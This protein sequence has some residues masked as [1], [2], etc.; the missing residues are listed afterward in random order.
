[1][2]T[3]HSTANHEMHRIRKSSLSKFFSR[4]QMLK[5]EDEARDFAQLTVDKMLRCAGKEPFDNKSAFNCFTAECHLPVLLRRAH[6]FHRSGGLGPQLCYVGKAFSRYLLFDE[7]QFPGEKT[8]PIFSHAGRLHWATISRPLIDRRVWLSRG[9]STRL[10]PTLK[11]GE[12]F[13]KCPSPSHFRSPRSPG[14]GFRARDLISCWPVRRLPRYGCRSLFL[15]LSHS[16][17]SCP[18]NTKMIS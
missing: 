8:G 14:F 17:L 9:T 5:L 15:H 6:G 2:L 13:A 10:W 18:V 16:I 11:M 7:T 12:C 3:A 1:M 4:Q